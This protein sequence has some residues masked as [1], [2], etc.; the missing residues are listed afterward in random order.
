VRPWRA[1]L[2]AFVSA[3]L[4]PSAS[5]AQSPPPRYDAAWHGGI[6]AG[7]LLA[8]VVVVARERHRAPVCSWCGVDD[9]GRPDVP[10]VDRWA[11][12]HWHWEDEGLASAISHGTVTASI[13]W[14]L[15]ALTA[16]HGGTGGEWG[17]DQVVALESTL[18]GLLSADLAKRLAR[19]SRPGVV[20]NREPID[21][22][23][24]VHSLFS[25]HASTAFAA[26]A[27]AGTI[28]SRRHSADAAWIWGGGLALAGTT[29]YL[30]VAATRHYL[31]DVLVGSAVGTAIGLVLPRV[32]DHARGPGATAA[33]T[34]T[35]L[36]GLGPAVAVGR[37][38]GTV[39]AL[40]PAAGARSF[41]VM[42]TVPV[43]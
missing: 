29:S 33:S 15:V 32:F 4:V 40:Q 2:A 3:S 27:A 14:P 26:V 35:P 20:F 13:V 7:A 28:A 12:E 42:A 43:R 23:D 41:G 11:Y 38:A 36:A 24:D 39:V 17:R 19:R 34:Q 6:A 5:H 16:V 1:L 10:R 8:S 18:V 21:A 37:A 22:M 30:R 25:S 31:T 9:N